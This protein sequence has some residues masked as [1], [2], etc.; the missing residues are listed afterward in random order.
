MTVISV[1]FISL[2]AVAGIGTGRVDAVRVGRAPVLPGRTLV[3]LY[4][5]KLVRACVA[6]LALADV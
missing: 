6:L 1:A 2:N 4:A 3:H 5:V